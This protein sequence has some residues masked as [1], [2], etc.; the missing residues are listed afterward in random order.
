MGRQRTLVGFV[1]AMILEPGLKGYVK[2]IEFFI[3][4][5][6]L[7]L[8]LSSEQGQ[9]DTRGDGDCSCL[10]LPTSVVCQQLENEFGINSQELLSVNVSLPGTH[11]K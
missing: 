6:R 9:V 1:E 11:T 3:S 5:Q 10:Y 4:T 2:V 7:R 8:G